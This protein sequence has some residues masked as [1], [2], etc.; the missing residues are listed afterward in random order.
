MIT[1]KNVKDKKRGVSSKE[2]RKKKQIEDVRN[3]RQKDAQ[4]QDKQKELLMRIT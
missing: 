2:E 3:M 4:P 1:N